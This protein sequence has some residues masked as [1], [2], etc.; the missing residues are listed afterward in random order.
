VRGERR[1][2]HESQEQQSDVHESTSI[3]PSLDRS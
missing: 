1:S 2:N 3:R